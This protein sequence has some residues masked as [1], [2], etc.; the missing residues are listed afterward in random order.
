MKTIKT[1][2]VTPEYVEF[3]PES[4]EMKENV[5]YISKKYETASHLCLCGCGNL[6]ITPTEYNW[7]TIT[8]DDIITITPSIG[9]YSFDCKSHYIITKNKANFV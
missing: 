8:G 7:W 3:I 9:N 4:S 5:I 6:T 1:V 2:Q